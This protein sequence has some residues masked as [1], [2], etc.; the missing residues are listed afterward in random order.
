[1]G[2]CRVRNFH[3]LAREVQSIAAESKENNDHRVEDFKVSEWRS[4]RCNDYDTTK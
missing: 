3:E 2:R 1:M 4:F